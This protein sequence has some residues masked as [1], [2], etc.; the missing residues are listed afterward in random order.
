MQAADRNLRRFHIQ[1]TMARP[2]LQE[3]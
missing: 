1:S 2:I 3:D